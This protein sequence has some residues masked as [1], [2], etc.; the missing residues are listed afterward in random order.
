MVVW[1]H[2][3]PLEANRSYLLKCAKQTIPVTIDQVR[4]RFDI[5]Q[6]NREPSAELE[7]NGIGRVDLLPIGPWHL[8]ST[9][10]NATRDA[11]PDRYG[12]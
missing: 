5:N 11:L 6:L 9:A 8:T 7:M 10:A 3:T 2:E 1:M 12:E 4:Y